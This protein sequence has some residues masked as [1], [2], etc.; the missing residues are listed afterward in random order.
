MRVPNA[1]LLACTVVILIA[2]VSGCSQRFDGSARQQYAQG[3]CLQ[4]QSLQRLDT[5]FRS[6]NVAAI[7]TA[8]RQAAGAA[9]EVLRALQRPEWPTPSR[10]EIQVL[11]AGEQAVASNVRAIAST[12]SLPEIRRIPAPP[13][14]RIVGLY[15]AD[16]ALRTQVKLYAACSGQM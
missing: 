2:T 5:A 3:R 15:E 11:Q 10:H 12:N 14:D 6:N 8:A 9:Q 13:H 16:Q 4:M 1:V 7:N